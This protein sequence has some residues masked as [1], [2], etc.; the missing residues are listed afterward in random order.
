[1][2]LSV[3][4]C[5]PKYPLINLNSRGSLYSFKSYHCLANVCSSASFK[6][7]HKRDSFFLLEKTRINKYERLSYVNTHL[8]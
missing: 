3:N 7:T 8:I 4:I 5:L 6:N 1:M 2:G